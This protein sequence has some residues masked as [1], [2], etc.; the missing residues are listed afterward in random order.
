ML[1][2][3]LV[4]VKFQDLNTLKTVQK[5]FFNDKIK[6]VFYAEVL[7]RTYLKSYKDCVGK[8]KDVLSSKVV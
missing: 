2:H 7:F 3:N 1:L 8:M 6:K 5:S 4:L